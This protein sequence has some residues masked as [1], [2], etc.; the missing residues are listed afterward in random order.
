MVYGTA[1][2]V[3]RFN[4]AFNAQDIDAV[5][6]AMTA[7]CC[8]ESTAPAPDGVR[9]SGAEQ[10]RAYWLK[11]FA[12]NPG[13]RFETEEM[14]VAGERCIVRWVYRKNK[15]GLPWHLRGVDL[16]RIR[17]GKVSEKLSYVKG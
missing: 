6:E 8:F 7:D 2:A 11:F 12:A 17:D 10:V 3:E 14:I 15:Q 16:F 5:M 1:E 13:A 9:Y 4:L